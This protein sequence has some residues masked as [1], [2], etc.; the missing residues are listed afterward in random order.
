M[1]PFDWL[2]I[3]IGN[4]GGPA[5]AARALGVSRQTVYGWVDDGLAKASFEKV[6]MLSVKADVPLEY[7]AK[8]LGPWD[9]PLELP[10]LGRLEAVKRGND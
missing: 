5:A 1:G 2:A 7:L 10:K 4:L 6:V 3:A 8:R 9:K